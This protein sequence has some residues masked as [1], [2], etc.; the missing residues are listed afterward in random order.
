MAYKFTDMKFAMM[1]GTTYV[2]LTQY[3]T[4]MTLKPDCEIAE[5]QLVGRPTM[6][7]QPVKSILE[8]GLTGYVLDDDTPPSREIFRANDKPLFMFLIPN[9]RVFSF[10]GY[11]TEDSPVDDGG[12]LILDIPLQP[13]NGYLT[14]HTSK[15]MTVADVNVKAGDLLF[16]WLTAELL[17]GG[18]GAIEFSIK[19]DQKIASIVTKPG[20]YLVDPGLTAD[21]KG[22]AAFN[23][24]GGTQVVGTEIVWGLGDLR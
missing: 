20:I 4:G 8:A 14:T 2:D 9:G 13:T 5:R 17:D 12:V 24:T 15:T 1:N 22:D 23:V 3:I 16:Y 19:G 11:I 18:T 6:W 21:E 7:R 10:N